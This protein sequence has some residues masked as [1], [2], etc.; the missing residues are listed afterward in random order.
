MGSRGSAAAVA[1][2]AVPASVA[3]EC[4]CP[5]TQGALLD[6][7]DKGAGEGEGE[8]EREEAGGATGDASL[9]FV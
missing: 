6:A 8:E 7:V 3:L 1:A 5:C 9:D 2:S 4:C